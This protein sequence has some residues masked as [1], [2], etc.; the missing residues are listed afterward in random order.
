MEGGFPVYVPGQHPGPPVPDYY[1]RAVYRA[2]P[3]QFH[4]EVLSPAKIG[5]AYCYGMR[6]NPIH[7]DGASIKSSF[8]MSD[9]IIWRR[10][11][12]CL[13]FQDM[14]EIEYGMKAREKRQR[15][16][17]GKGV[18]KNGMYIHDRAASFESLPPG[19]DPKSVSKD[20]H[21]YLP[22]LAKK[23]TLFRPSQSTIEQRHREFSAL[24][25]AFFRDDVPAL[26]SELRE[27]R[28]IRDF[29]GHWRRD[30]DIA[31]KRQNKTSRTSQGLGNSRFSSMYF[32][33]S[34]IS[35]SLPNS[36]PD[37][38]TSVPSTPI[39]PHSSALLSRRVPDNNGKSDATPS[40]YDSGISFYFP[41]S[42]APARMDA[43]ESQ[44]ELDSE[45]T[46]KKK[47]ST[48]SSNSSSSSSVP[49][50]PPMPQQQQQPSRR[51]GA[52]T[53]ASPKKKKICYG[54]FPLASERPGPSIRGLEA[55]PEG[56]ELGS[57]PANEPMEDRALPVPVPRSRSSSKMIF[58]RRKV[59]LWSSTM[60]QV[61]TF[62]QTSPPTSCSRP[63]SRRSS[64]QTPESDLSTRARPGS[65]GS[66]ASTDIDIPF[67]DTSKYPLTPQRTDRF[68][69]PVSA[70]LYPR[71]STISMDSI[72][73]GTPAEE[74]PKQRSISPPNLPP[75]SS[76]LSSGL[77]RSGLLRSHSASS[78]RRPRSFS[79]PLPVPEEE[80]WPDLGEDFL[81]SYMSDMEL[82]QSFTDSELPEFIASRPQTP[83]IPREQPQPQ[84]PN[85]A[86]PSARR[87]QI[88]MPLSP[89]YYPRLQHRYASQYHLPFTPPHPCPSLPLPEI[90]PPSPTPTYSSSSTTSDDT[91]VVK[92]ALDD[93]IVVFRAP[94]VISLADMRNRIHDK[95]ARQEGLP[96]SAP[97]SI[98][99]LPPLTP[100]PVARPRMSS[101]SSVGPAD[102]ARMLT[103]ASEDEW[104]RAVAT[105]A[106]KLVLRVVPVSQES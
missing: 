43:F 35:L 19:P 39:L 102:F 32:A 11:E 67:V 34:N 95:F 50:P 5:G 87:Q 10:W 25:E 73:I 20:I 24:I 26:I 36:Y 9:Y 38:P 76:S 51:P 62:F 55:L 61:E 105:C 37:V 104:E 100:G 22:K 79:Q 63:Q 42:S 86:P 91:L 52:S 60:R 54:G 96:L 78:R 90:P 16:A 6:I 98:A 68:S 45:H 33:P 75:L 57:S 53:K 44:R 41:P 69:V 15:L 14:L 65:S 72:E 101:I 94:R 4:V 80:S 30:H 18:K 82:S 92:A 40:L 12:D 48:S 47:G 88:S 17:A 27:D 28:V 89:D 58:H 84:Q 81:E 97:F 2:A 7:G 77:L 70:G 83:N 8:T 3:A 59:T 1:K 56:H 23:G 29:F 31:L 99:Y 93:A 66:N 21:D 74:F 85:S 49:P 46:I 13:W 106:A 64:C 71:L 103:I